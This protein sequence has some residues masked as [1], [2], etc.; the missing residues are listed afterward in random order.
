L[1]SRERVIRAIEFNDPDRIP[2]F[3]YFL[4]ATFFRYGQRFRELLMRYPSDFVVPLWVTDIEAITAPR[5]SYMKERHKDEL[6]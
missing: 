5:P 4:P 6:I 1:T 3:H 2:H